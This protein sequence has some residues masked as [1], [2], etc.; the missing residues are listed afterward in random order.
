[1]AEYTC[2]MCGGRFEN[3]DDWTE[4]DRLAEEKK[5]FGELR[6][7]E[8]DSVCDPCFQKVHPENYPHAVEI[9]VEAVQRHRLEERHGHSAAHQ[10][11]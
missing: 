7:D 2:A 3:P 9:A 1:M 8:R 4:E 6:P 10:T 11:P 5:Y